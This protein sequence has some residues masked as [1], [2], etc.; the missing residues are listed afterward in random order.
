MIKKLL[1]R[2]LPS[3]N[4]F[5]GGLH[6]T[7]PH[8]KNMSTGAPSR[9]AALSVEYAISL[10]QRD[11]SAY[12]AKVAPGERVLRGQLLAEPVNSQD[13]PVHAPTSGT[14]RAIEPRPEMHPANQPV[15]HLILASDGKDESVPP[16]TALDPATTDAD[17]LR[18]RIAACGIVGLGGAGFPTARKLGHPANTLVINAAECEPYITCDDLQIRENAADI[19]HGAQIAAKILGAE[20]IHFGIEDDKPQA[21]AALERAAADIN[22]PRLKISSVPTRYPSGNARQLFELL[23]G[24]RVP[25]DQHASDYG[26]IC[27]NSGTMKAVYDAVI[28]GEP[29]TERYTTISGEGVNQP[30]VLRIRTGAPVR[31]LIAQAGGEKGDNRYIIGGP[32]MGYQI[33]SADTPLQKTGN[34]LLLLPA[35]APAEESPCIRCSRCADACPMELLPQQLLWYSQ[36]DEHK[37][38]KQYRLYDCIECG[39]CAAVCP[40]AIPLVQYYRHSKGAIRAA[41]EKARAAEHA[42]TRHEARTARLEREAAE[43]QAQMDARRAK[44]QQN[45]AA[46]KPERYTPGKTATVT[47]ADFPPPPMG[48]GQGRGSSANLAAESSTDDKTATIEAAK[49]RA[50]ARRAERLA[51]NGEAPKEQLPPLQGASAPAAGEGWGGGNVPDS[52]ANIETTT[53]TAPAPHK[54]PPDDAKTAAIEAAKARAAARKAA[55]LAQNSEA[56]TPAAAAS[57][58]EPPLSP[59]ERGWGEGEKNE[60]KAPAPHQLPP[61]DAKTAAIEAAK[62]RAAARRAERLAQNAEAKISTA[63]ASPTKQPPPPV[64]EGRGGGSKQSSAASDTDTAPASPDNAKTAAIE[65]AKA[66]AAARKAAR[67]AQNSE[68]ETPAAAA[69]P[70]EQP[71]SPWERGWGEG[72]KNEDKEPAP[73]Q[74]PPDDAKTAAIEAAKARAAARKAARLAQNSEA[75][76]AAASASPSVQPPSPV[77]EGGGGGNVPDFSANIETTTDTA[78][79]PH[80]LPPDDAKI[81]AIEA[82]KA[83]AAARKAARLANQSPN[84]DSPL[85]NPLTPPHPSPAGGGSASMA[86]APTVAETPSEP[87]PPLQ[88]ASAPAAGEGGG[89][90]SVPAFSANIETTTDTAPAPHQLPPDDA[91]I[92]A[93]EAA[94][95]RAAARKTARLAQNSEAPTGQPITLPQTEEQAE[96]SMTPPDNDDKTAR[97]AKLAAARAKS[98]ERRIAHAKLKQHMRD[99]AIPIRPQPDEHQ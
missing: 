43:R 16:L 83:R 98:E 11:G 77:G 63:P 56:E 40:S 17:A 7:P 70:A 95:A 8:H 10:R 71:L 38:L 81:A 54:L 57:P 27:H 9:E 65:A 28:R 44:L 32:M 20:H 30:Q 90:G 24:V 1:A 37:R 48:E 72:E 46:D 53:D 67:L 86:E 14:I 45:P 33:I 2:L 60:D 97:D 59:W 96:T 58:T 62:A 49:A 69:S 39:I 61:D 18:E 99:T 4:H 89:G 68:A 23:L 3:K 34:S 29:L 78:P 35:I 94:K 93:I 64:G 50:A 22:D 85:Q 82:A 66:R 19:I 92:A 73:H 79:A 87:P 76:T 75:D 52:S 84:N 21:I 55:R 26:L 15:P 25:A 6:I 42:R 80:Q 13:A 88:G 5:H 12:L 74:L 36:S 41:D 47:P 91:K 31:D 51:Q